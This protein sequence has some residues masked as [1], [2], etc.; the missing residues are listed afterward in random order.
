MLA[1]AT[2]TACGLLV[3]TSGLSGGVRPDDAGDPA[4]DATVADT[5]AA[6]PDADTGDAADADAGPSYRDLV[7]SDGPVAFYLLADA[8]GSTTIIDETGNHPG[9]RSGSLV[10]REPGP[11]TTTPSVR[12]P[13]GS[14]RVTANSVAQ[15]PAGTFAAY[16]IEAFVSSEVPAGNSQFFVTFKNSSA[17]G[18]PGLFVDDG[19]RSVKYVNDGASLTSSVSLLT[20]AWHHVAVTAAATTVSIYIDGQFD[21]STTVADPSPDRSSFTIGSNFINNGD[22]GTYYGGG[23]TGRLAMVAVYAKALGAQQI[24]AHYAARPR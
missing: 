9:T 21:V 7:M 5:G 22:G 2:A 4:A 6:P 23:F 20:T 10:F 11:G 18:G 12:F 3:D 13:G 8:T 24:A 16:T 1:A 17:Y 14:A 19:T 15:L